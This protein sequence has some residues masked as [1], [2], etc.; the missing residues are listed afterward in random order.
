MIAVFALGTLGDVQPLLILSR[1]LLQNLSD[2]EIF[3]VTNS[4]QM[5]AVEMHFPVSS[6]YCGGGSRC[7]KSRF[8]VFYIKA[9]SLGLST[10]SAD[11]F[12]SMD[13]LNKICVEVSLIENLNLVIA[14]L[15]CLA[16][17]FVAKSRSVPCVLIHP[18]KPPSLP[19]PDFRASLKRCDPILYRK[20]VANNIEYSFCGRQPPSDKRKN[21]CTSLLD[22]E[23]WLWP[24]LCPMYDSTHRSLHISSQLSC[25]SDILP[26]QPIVLLAVSPRYYI[27]P[28]Y[29]PADQYLVTGYI[30]NKMLEA[31]IN[32]D[33]IDENNIFPSKLQL[34][35]DIQKNNTVCIDFG[36]MTELLVKEYDLKT[37]ILTILQ[38]KDFSFI[39]SC[40]GYKNIFYSTFLSFI[41]STDLNIGDRNDENIRNDDINRIYFLNENINHSLL[42]KKCIAVLHHGGA[43]TVGTSLLEGIPQG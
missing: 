8:S 17:W 43:G 34:F 15:F 6:L 25:S 30:T 42:F 14:N 32:S 39:I 31:E 29:W 21:E 13:E 27:I 35:L 2:V 28:G 4:A 23:E 1:Y 40:H 33:Q 11:D 38:L 36:S 22:Y 7:H 20:L 12:F 37:F 19:P 5:E 10:N 16:G 9:P 24:T 26:L 18:H 41:S 3:F